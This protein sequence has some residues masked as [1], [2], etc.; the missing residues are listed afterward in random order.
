MMCKLNKK[1]T[2][3]CWR[4]KMNFE[5]RRSFLKQGGNGLALS[6]SACPFAAL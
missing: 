6:L 2:C 3:H 5:Q 1:L 4:Q